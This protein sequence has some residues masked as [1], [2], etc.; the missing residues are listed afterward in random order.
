MASVLEEAFKVLRA[1]LSSSS[2]NKTLVRFLVVIML[3]LSITRI[4][5]S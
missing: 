4:A 2:F 1:F 3:L 5:K